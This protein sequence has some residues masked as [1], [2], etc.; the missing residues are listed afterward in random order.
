[1]VGAGPVVWVWAVE[2][3]VVEVGWVCNCYMP[4]VITELSAVDGRVKPFSRTQPR[5][6]LE[7]LHIEPTFI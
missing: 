1:V 7:A 6:V 2:V 3:E 4:A 5:R